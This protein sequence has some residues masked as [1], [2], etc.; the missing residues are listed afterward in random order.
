MALV[1][2]PLPRNLPPLDCNDNDDDDTN[3]EATTTTAARI[4]QALEQL[5]QQS[6]HVMAQQIELQA[7][8]ELSNLYCNSLEGGGGLTGSDVECIVM[9]RPPIPFCMR[10]IAIPCSFPYSSK[11]CR[12]NSIPTDVV[13][14]PSF[15][16]NP[17]VVVLLGTTV[18]T[19]PMLGV[20][21][22]DEVTRLLH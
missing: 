21:M 10:T 13:I 6:N 20:P 2:P 4:E 16:L 18:S 5:L 3:V 17:F 22:K 11:A 1:A 12:N 14:P 15:F 8:Q 19:R 7:L 9:A